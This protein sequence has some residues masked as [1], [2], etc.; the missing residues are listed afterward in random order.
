MLIRCTLVLRMHLTFQD[1]AALRIA[2][3]AQRGVEVLFSLNVLQTRSR[4][5]RF[6][7]WLPGGRRSAAAALLSEL[8]VPS[9]LPGY[10]APAVSPDWSETRSNALRSDPDSRRTDIEQL[11]LFRPAT[12]FARALADD[13]AEARKRFAW[14]LSSFQRLSMD[15]WMPQIDVLM[16]TER[17]D[18]ARLAAE[19][20]D[21]LLSNLHPRVY[22]KPPVLHMDSA[23][24]ADYH[25]GGCG[26]LIQPT[27]F[28]AARPWLGTTDVPHPQPVLFV[29]LRRPLPLGDHEP[30]APQDL[31][32]LLGRTR[33]TILSVLTDEGPTS[34]GELA[35]RV[36]C[37]PST[38]S[39]HTEVL[40]ESGLIT[41]VREGKSVRHAATELGAAVRRGRT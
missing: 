22:W 37:S 5:L 32:R 4:D 38:V 18:W 24:D 28:G 10:L 35:R 2:D 39:N 23:I 40:R 21:R 15:T 9:L 14:A 17:D 6:H 29:P 27:Y 41:T 16:R 3:E 13:D 11:A 1:L 7:R 33:A 34:N 19:G 36:D 26:L 20:A 12:P 30:V 31:I 25:L 8:F